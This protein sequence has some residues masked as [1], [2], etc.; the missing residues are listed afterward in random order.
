MLSRALLSSLDFGQLKSYKINRGC[1]A[2]THT[3]FANDTLLFG[4]ATIFETLFLKKI[5]D[6][7]CEA[8]GQ[9]LNVQKS[10]ITFSGD[11]PPDIKKSIC[12]LLSI[13]EVGE[14][15]AYMGLPMKWVKS[16]S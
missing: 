5:L 8:S 1:P 3:Q 2:L 11:T 6:S 7:Y 15:D 16:K 9:K 13:K 10:S 4:L 14:K 12:G